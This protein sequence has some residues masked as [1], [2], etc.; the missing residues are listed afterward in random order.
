MGSYSVRL[1][2]FL[3]KPRYPSGRNGAIG[4]SQVRA[5]ARTRSDSYS[6]PRRRKIRYR[7]VLTR[8]IKATAN[9]YPKAQLSSGMFWKFMP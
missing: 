4:P 7:V 9:G 1:A 3:T 8:S 2:F 5:H 6:Q